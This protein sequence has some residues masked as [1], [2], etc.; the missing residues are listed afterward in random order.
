VV[1]KYGADALRLY[2]INSP[3]VRAETLRFKEEGVRGVIK[4][5]F[6]PW[7]NA[8]RFLVQAVRRYE[9]G[10]GHAGEGGGGAG[11]GGEEG[12]EEEEEEEEDE[13]EGG[14]PAAASAAAA[15]P[16]GA[17][18]AAAGPPAAAAGASAGGPARAFDPASVDLAA[19]ATNVLDVWVVAA[20]RALVSCVREEM[21]S[22]RLYAVVPELVRFVE[23]LT[24]VYVRFNRGRLKGSKGPGD[25]RVALATLHRVL[26]T[27]ASAMAPFTPFLS[28][29]M[30]RNLVRALPPRS[31]PESVH[32]APFPADPGPPSP[33][34]RRIRASVDRMTRVVDL[35]RAL[36]ERRGAP[37][38]RPLRR[39]IVVHPDPEFLAD[40][41][42]RLREY[43]L[44]ELNV[45]EVEA[46]ADPLRY[47]SVRAEP[48]WGALAA[49][50][51]GRELPRVA[52][53]LRGLGPEAVLALER[54]G[55]GEGEGVEVAGVMLGKGDVR[56]IREFRAPGA[57][58]EAP[59]AAAAASAAE[60]SSDGGGKK[61]G[62]KKGGGG[63]KK[64]GGADGAPAAAAA[65]AAPL[66]HLDAAGDGDVL[67][68][69]DF[70]PD[71]ALLRAGAAREVVNRFMRLR[72]KAGLVPTDPVELFWRA[73]DGA[74]VGD[75]GG[76]GMGDGDGG[77]SASG[78]GG[79]LACLFAEGS[80]ELAYM[81]AALVVP[82]R[83][84]PADGALPA[85]LVE[86][87]R[88]EATL[89]GGGG[90]GGGDGGNGVADGDAGGPSGGLTAVIAAPEGSGLAER[91]AAAAKVSDTEAAAP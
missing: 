35:G 54:A 34:D 79:G 58:G 90:G 42:G 46:C 44:S 72:K 25:A 62:G 31:M 68:V 74:G 20:S 91:L 15:G 36:R 19:E 45:R 51:L 18:A 41:A 50:G 69:L 84:L 38:K 33:A 75:G 8:Y 21:A 32:F 2:L 64:G 52:A 65:D 70:E 57:D 56:V 7:Y 81:R 61:G 66:G 83:A 40:V 24:N 23:R 16:A 9:A 71:P 80:D 55:E 6:L 85:G 86:L 11:A 12:G 10:I 73:A 17:A 60:S 39:A 4:D 13:D 37:L 67:V 89:G 28:E 63:G 47:C 82:L 30:Y 76:A 27:L 1:D 78:G 43:V 26:L 87:A 77:A 88:D 22:Y 59:G 14:G 5:V 49:R 53:A 48:E 29:L 3:V